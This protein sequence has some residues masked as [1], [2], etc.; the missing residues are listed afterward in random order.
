MPETIM[1]PMRDG[2]RLATDVFLPMGRGRFPVIMERTPYGRQE[3]SRS[4]ITAVNSAPASRAEIAAYFTAHG[5]AV[6]YQDTR[7]R[8]G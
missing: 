1:V 8:Y 5:Y 7:G 4:E 2:I 6:L 3:T